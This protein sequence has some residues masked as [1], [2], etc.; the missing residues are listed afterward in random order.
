M[1]QM[2]D[3]EDDGCGGEFLRVRVTMDVTKPLARCSKLWAEG[4]HIGWVGI[5]YERLPNFYY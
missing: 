2:A 4:K 1:V 5:K 3:P